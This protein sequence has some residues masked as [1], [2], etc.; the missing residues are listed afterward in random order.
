MMSIRN[1]LGTMAVIYKQLWQ[2]ILL[3]PI[4]PLWLSEKKVTL[5]MFLKLKLSYLEKGYEVVCQS[6]YSS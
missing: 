1:M 6:A 3:F 5:L 2:A 4:S